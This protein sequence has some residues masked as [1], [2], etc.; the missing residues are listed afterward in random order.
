[1]SSENILSPSILA[2]DFANLGKQLKEIE[3]AGAS[4][5]HIDVMDGLFVPSI[6]FGMPLIRSIRKVSGLTFDVHLMIEEPVRYVRDFRDCGADI[7]TVHYEACKDI[8]AT[9]KEIRDTG[10]RAGL[11]IKPGTSVDVVKE[12]LPLCDMV[13]LMSVEPGFG[14][15]KFMEVSYERAEMLHRMIL[16][17]GYPVDL[18]IDGGITL[19]NVSSVLDAG[20]NVIVAGSAVFKDPYNNTK[21]FIKRLN[22]QTKS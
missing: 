10:A 2:A 22:T 12:L 18:Q 15:Q 8:A 6:S 20:V 11:S 9:M 13:L 7:I 17:S 1:M 3:Q 16:D 5:V 14:G 4:Y 21:E 19:D